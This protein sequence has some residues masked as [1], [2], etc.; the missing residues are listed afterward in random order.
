M[1]ILSQ[2][3]N[4]CKWTHDGQCFL[5][6]SFD[7][8]S[9]SPSHIYHSA[10]PFSPS[11]S[12]LHGCYTALLSQGVKVVKGLP[13]EWGTYSRTIIM[14]SLPWVLTCWKDTMAVSSGSHIIILSA[15]TGSQVA[16]LS[17]HTDAVRSLIF[18]L[19]VALLVSGS[20][21]TTAK[22]W[23][24]QTGGV[25]R[26][27]CGHTGHVCS[28]SI[29]PD[30]TTLASGSTD[31]SIRLWGVWTGECFCVIDGHIA[32]VRSVSFSPTNSQHL[33][34]SS[35]DHTIKQWDINGHQIGPT[36]EGDGV[37]FSLDGT[38][39]VSWWKGVAT[40]QNSESGVVTT[41]LQA[42]SDD[43]RC[44]C[45]S[46]S[47]EFVAGCVNH[48]I[49]VWDITLSD[50]HLFKTFVGHTDNITA[51]TFSSSLIS[52]S[53]DNS[54]RFWQIGASADPVTTD[55]MSTPPTS[56]SIE[57]VS[58]QVRKG[59]AIS[60]DSDG[61]V[62]TWD[63]LTGLCKG[64]SQTP[65]KG[66]AS[67]DAQLIEDRVIL[68]WYAEEKIHIWDVEK[69]E[70]VKTVDTPETYAQGI[71]ISEDGSK[72][73]CLTEKSIQAWYIWTGEP[74]G[75]VVGCSTSN[76]DP[77]HADGSKIWVHSSDSST[78]GW[79]FGILGSSPIPLPDTFPNRPH[80]DLNIPHNLWGTSESRIEDAVTRTN[81]FQLVE[82]YAKPCD[83]RWDGQYLIAGYM[84]G[85]V[86]ILD[87]NQ[88]LSRYT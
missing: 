20:R 56:A 22:L 78:E 53:V 73:F 17:G 74:V 62:K 70:L 55:V 32:W 34:S 60:S 9:K 2:T 61:V 15:I 38:H 59:I 31:K 24:L 27:F 75:K 80:L 4:S 10:L 18:S 64:S 12:W 86:L 45:F 63:I 42:H 23:D 19:D 79:D 68:V 48:T 72:V 1:F 3:G 40:V 8:I 36:H 35:G 83:A 43:L 85:E 16:V 30:S 29:S 14:D 57:S 46:P 33:V 76:L 54:V 52:A 25:I 37:A 82:R 28:V 88:C 6:E 81:V 26:T 58:L 69:D 65:A 66:Q 77:F 71:R 21:D 67:R 41:K 49:Y 51:L 7:L 13:S 39:F 50:P 44:C 84:S 47:G 87:F 5:L 11:S